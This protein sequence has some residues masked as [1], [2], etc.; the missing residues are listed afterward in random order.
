MSRVWILIIVVLVAIVAQPAAARE[1]VALVIGNG[2]YQ[3]A[4]LANPVRDAGLVGEALGAV[5]FSVLRISD[6]D[7][8]GMRR[9]IQDFADRLHDAGADAVGLVYFAGHGVEVAGRNYLIPVGARIRR[10]SDVA[11]EAV[12]ADEVLQIFAFS[13][14]A[15]NMLV[16]D[17]CRNNPYARGFRSASRGLAR[18]DAPTGTLIAY[19]TSP[20]SVAVDGSGDNSPYSAA[21]AEMIRQPGLTVEA[22]FKRVRVSVMASTA[23]EQ[24][25]WEASS[26]V[27]DFFFNG[28]GLAGHGGVRPLS[29]DAVF[30]NAIE[31]SRRPEDFRDYLRRFPDGLFAGLARDRIERLTTPAQTPAET[32]AKTPAQTPEM[33]ALVP[34]ARPLQAGEPEASPAKP[35][36]GRTTK[37]CLLGICWGE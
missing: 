11:I 28:P 25:P 31:E 6:A 30:W 27:G 8:R 23:G 36:F 5:G 13:P 33:T 7:Q 34:A 19:A 4:P 2:A 3:S 17:A 20:G 21:L 12:A 29:D 37:S 1:R 10:E 14:N 15:F 22:A 32:P 9:A 18:M 16:L 24:V 35:S 26:L